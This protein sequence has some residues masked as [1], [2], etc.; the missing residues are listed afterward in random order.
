MCA[1]VCLCVCVPVC[2][3]LCVCVCVCVC[4]CVYVY[5]PV[6]LCVLCD[7]M[8]SVTCVRERDLCETDLKCDQ[9]VSVWVKILDG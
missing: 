5:V 4:M 7:T 6:Y 1:Y 8:D 2:V 9:R 3:C